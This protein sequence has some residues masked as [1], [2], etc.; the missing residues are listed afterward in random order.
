ME[1]KYSKLTQ[2]TNDMTGDVGTYHLEEET[3][4]TYKTLDFNTPL[5]LLKK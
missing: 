4:G 2:I 1:I 5:R 3:D